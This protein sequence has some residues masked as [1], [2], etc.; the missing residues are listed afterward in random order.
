LNGI[1]STIAFNRD[2]SGMWA[3]GSYSNQV[4][5]FDRNN[6]QIQLLNNQGYGSGIS[7][8]KR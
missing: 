1:I 4:A 7:Q 3:A 6:E 8:V 5:L 2:S